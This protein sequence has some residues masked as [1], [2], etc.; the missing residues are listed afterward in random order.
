MLPYAASLQLLPWPLFAAPAATHS[1]D[2]AA[3]APAGASSNAI[4]A[5]LAISEERPADLRINSPS[6]VCADFAAFRGGAP[7]PAAPPRRSSS[8]VPSPAILDGRACPCQPPAWRRRASRRRRRLQARRVADRP[9]RPRR[10]VVEDAPA[11]SA[12][13]AIGAFVFAAA[14]GVQTQPR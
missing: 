4:A 8:Q 14:D 12:F 2:F 13:V 7:R 6:M 11:R 5:T 1:V 3:C 9:A 10:Q